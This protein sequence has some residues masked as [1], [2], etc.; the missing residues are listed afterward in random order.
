MSESAAAGALASRCIVTTRPLAQAQGLTNALEA[1]GAEAINFPVIAI[2]AADPLPLQ[3]LDLG[4][5]ALAF[6][7]SA[8]AIDHAFRIRPR[9][10]WP[11]AVRV[12]AVGPA[13]AQAL[14][15]RGWNAVI[16]PETGFDS[17]SVLA[18]PEFSAARLAGQRVLV[19]RGEGGRELLADTLRKRGALVDQISVYRRCRA[20][21]DPAPL[22]LRAARGELSA[23]V[24][25][26]SEGL[27]FFLEIM[28]DAGRR[29]LHEVPC[30]A[31]HPRIL[32]ALQQAGAARPVLT[33]PGD[34][35]IIESLV[36]HLHQGGRAPSGP[37]RTPD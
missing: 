37:T 34:A 14:V 15:S 24:F 25:S 12:A 17:E 7:V 23:L 28:A 3:V 10:S 4:A 31:P 16:S 9:A 18:L 26:A 32:E 11:D 8:N 2:E 21:L 19:L 22:L 1:L 13:S 5:Y 30:F 36:L 20:A 27:R 6:F 35:G 29:L 33:G